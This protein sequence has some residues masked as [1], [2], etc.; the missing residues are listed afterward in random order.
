M[1]LNWGFIDASPLL[2]GVIL[3]MG[4]KQLL[5]QVNQCFFGGIKLIVILGCSILSV[6][7]ASLC[8]MLPLSLNSGVK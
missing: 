7:I 4:V 2:R 6:F 3:Q 5:I 1:A 8:F